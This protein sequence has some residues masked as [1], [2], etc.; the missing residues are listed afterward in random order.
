[1]N[2]IVVLVLLFIHKFYFLYVER[3]DLSLDVISVYLFLLFMIFSLS[4]IGIHIDIIFRKHKNTILFISVLLAIIWFNL[5]YYDAGVFRDNIP[6]FMGYSDQN[7]Y[8]RMI[9]SLVSGT[10]GRSD[11][12]YGLGYPMLGAVFYHLYENDP[13]FYVNFICYIIIIIYLYNFRASLKTHF[14]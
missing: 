2:I 13:L 9:N 3:T 11:Y 4:K 6:A 1:M 14:N 8:Y 12:Y 10:F 5:Y 7:S